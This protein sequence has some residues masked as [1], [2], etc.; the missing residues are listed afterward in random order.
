MLIREANNADLPG[1]LAIYNDVVANTTAIYEDRPSTL[2]ER[3]AWMDERRA[4]GWPVL[5][6]D[7]DGQV[8]GFSTFGPWRSRWG[9]R[10]TVEHSVHVHPDYRGKG[11]GRAL[12]EALF[13][14]AVDLGMHVMIAQIDAEATASL[15]LHSRLGFRTVGTFHE[16]A[17]KFGRWLDLVVMER[18]V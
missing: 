3:Q 4:Q 15:R 18:R 10:F 16:V 8:A 13:P 14:R 1:I 6:A 17:F 5:V 7:V 2:E 12:I 11:I 9:Y